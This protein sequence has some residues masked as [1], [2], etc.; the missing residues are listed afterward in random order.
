M[1]FCKIFICVNVQ[2]L[3]KQPSR[4]VGLR[5]LEFSRP[6]EQLFW[7]ISNFVQT[8]YNSLF[9]NSRQ[10]ILIEILTREFLHEIEMIFWPLHKNAST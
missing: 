10:T 7:K 3:N 1:L 5:S 8:E 2:I 6:L 9:K 4:H